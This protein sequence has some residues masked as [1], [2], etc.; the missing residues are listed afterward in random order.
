MDDELDDN[1]AHGVNFDEIM[2]MSHQIIEDFNEEYGTSEHGS[3]DE[4]HIP[5]PG[6]SHRDSDGIYETF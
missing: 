1:G 5:V 3:L 4:N 2:N 6:S